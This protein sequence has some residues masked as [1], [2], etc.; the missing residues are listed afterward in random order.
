MCNCEHGQI[1]G[2]DLVDDH[3]PLATLK[4]EV[5][6]RNAAL[7]ATCS[8]RRNVRT[9]SFLPSFK[10]FKSQQA[11]K[12]ENYCATTPTTR[13]KKAVRITTTRKASG[14]FGCTA[15]DL[16]PTGSMLCA[17]SCLPREGVF[18]IMSRRLA[19]LSSTS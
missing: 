4:T 6:T 8:F 1:V 5:L 16:E 12:G 11:R 7:T 2:Q 9:D 13:K 19:A 15:V 3:Q 10:P 17:G 18:S 14:V